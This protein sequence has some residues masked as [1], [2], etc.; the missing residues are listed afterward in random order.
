MKSASPVKSL[1]GKIRRSRVRKGEN[2]ADRIRESMR[3]I[4]RG[5]SI[6]MQSGP[7]FGE[8]RSA[9]R[10]KMTEIEPA[11]PDVIE[12]P[13]E[14]ETEIPPLEDEDDPVIAAIAEGE[15]GIEA[16]GEITDE[17][18]QDPEIRIP[19]SEPA[20]NT[21]EWDPVTGGVDCE[22]RIV[23]YDPGDGIP[24]AIPDPLGIL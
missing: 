8:N 13:R 3:R 20:E 4:R 23:V 18:L 2:M 12:L 14:I 6:R 21:F 17:D 5:N 24:R 15:A 19:G 16:E 22:P 7:A 1:R 11:A 9:R 10:C